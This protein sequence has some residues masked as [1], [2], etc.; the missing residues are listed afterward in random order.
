MNFKLKHSG[1]SICFMFTAIVGHSQVLKTM[2]KLPDTGQNTS[3]TNTFGEDNNYS[4]NVPVFKQVGNG[5]VLDTIT[6][7]A[8][9]M[10]DGGEMTV[11]NASNYCDTLNLNGNLLVIH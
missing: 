4:I 3:Y 11:E 8:W 5:C 9:Q 6:G 2:K 7:L 10:T 1:L